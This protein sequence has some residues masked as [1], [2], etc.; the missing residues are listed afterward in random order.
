MPSEVREEAE[1]QLKKLERMHPDAA[2]TS[3]LRNW[4]DWMV[5]LP[6]DAR[7]GTSSI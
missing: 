4:L 2:E 5:A 3:T 1:R 7:P 6:W